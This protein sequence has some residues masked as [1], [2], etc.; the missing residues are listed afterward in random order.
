ML[1]KLQYPLMF[2]LCMAG[3]S[4]LLYLARPLLLAVQY[5]HNALLTIIVG[6]LRA[7]EK[8]GWIF[9]SL[10]G[11]SF[12]IIAIPEY[13]GLSIIVSDTVLVV[14]RGILSSRDSAIP[15]SKIE[16]I[17]I[18]EESWQRF[19]GLATVH[20]KTSASAEGDTSIYPTSRHFAEQIR[21]ALLARIAPNS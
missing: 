15:Y 1:R 9:T 4:I 3:L 10:M 7:F 6:T 18:T 17:E 12:C 19:L 13:I 8:Y 20:I 2:A 16:T 21:T 5:N 14:R 11:V